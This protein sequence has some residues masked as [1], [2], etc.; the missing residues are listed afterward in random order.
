MTGQGGNNAIET[1]AALANNLVAAL[2]NNPSGDLSTTELSAIFQK[3]QQQREERT[4]NLVK[5]AHSRQRLEC[6]ESPTLKFVAKY[7]LPYIP[8]SPLTDRW[9]DAYSS[10]SSLD[11]VPHPD[12]GH[13]IP[14]YDELLKHPSPRGKSAYALYIVFAILA[15]AGF[16][17]L[18]AAAQVNGTLSLVRDSI[19][20]GS[21]G[22]LDGALR[23]S[24]TGVES[25]DQILVTLVTFF[26]P[27]VTST[28]PEQPLQLIYFL[29]SM[30]PLI[31]IF[32]VEGYR[33]R[34]RWSLVA[35]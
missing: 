2:K 31:A 27:T 20:S 30:L 14:F 22:N 26:L 19:I 18:F 8:Q 25:I 4:W 15:V 7:I 32:T 11:M 34:N 21:I 5:Q 3:T 29:S 35:R 10:G 1:A 24:Y 16:Q 9:I 33:Q 28:R 6:M 13:Q 17:L 23:G 12:R